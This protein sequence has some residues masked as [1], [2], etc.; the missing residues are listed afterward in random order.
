MDLQ[1]PIKD[2]GRAY[3]MFASRAERLDIHTLEDL[4]YH[5]PFRYEDYTHASPINTLQIGEKSVIRGIVTESRT[6]YTRR[7]FKIQ[8][9]TIQDDSG[10]L[11]CIWF[12]QPYITQILTQGSYVSLVGRVDEFRGKSVLMVKD[13]EKLP[14]PDAPAIHTGGLVAVYPETK[15]LTSKWIRNRIREVLSSQNFE[16]YLPSYVVKKYD[17]MSY[18]CALHEIHF[19]SN[20][21]NAMKARQRLSFDELFLTHLKALQRRAEWEKSTTTEAFKVQI[22]RAKVQIFI[23]S[24]PFELTNSQKNAIEDIFADVEKNKPMNR[25]LEGDVGSGKTI[26]AAVIIYLAWLN[27]FQSVLMAPTDILSNQHFKTLTTVLDS[28]GL[29][30]L[31]YTSASKKKMKNLGDFDVVVGTHAL[32]DDKL[33][34]DKLGLVVIDEQQRFGVEQRAVLRNKGESPHF[35]TMTATPIPR[36][37]FLTMYGD[38]DLSY[39]SDM[40]KGRKKVKTWLV[41][42]SKRKSGYE[43][44]RTQIMKND[45]NGQTNQAF[46]VCPF[47]EESE[48]A[49]TVKAA[50]KEFE[51]LQNEVF[52]D[53]KLG[54]LHGKIK[55]TEKD[56]VLADFH[57]G[58]IDILVA[59]PVV[60]VGIDIPNATIMVIEAADR[61]GLAQLHQLRG[62]V[63]RN[64][65]ES[66]CLLFADKPSEKTSMRLKNMETIYSGAELAEIDL[67]LRGPGDVYGTLQHGIP[68]LK[69]A[70][71]SDRKTLDTSK[72]EAQIIFK[73]LS[74]YPSLQAKLKSTIIQSVNPD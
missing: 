24:L 68:K 70:S 17:F 39:L 31:L 36:T 10:I 53:L 67:K 18:D 49:T 7:S 8:R 50:V 4:I 59:T 38:L 57:D 63:G 15:G 26:V 56:Q 64:D 52:P 54:L 9:A 2:A 42:E 29:K 5:F 58:K 51:H 73:Q 23:N 47:I 37:V 72:K 28:S 1:T 74:D 69:I 35:L 14:S 12:N 34:F 62:R 19:P 40:P 3:K 55:H 46:I 25:M 65:K 66:Y 30:V 11:E 13:Y 43:W 27:G 71:F 6:E 44:I 61:F 48:S 60:E 20:F 33:S 32:L 16:E 21:G 22:H 45:A 41:P